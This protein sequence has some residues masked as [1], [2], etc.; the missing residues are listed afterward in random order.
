[1]PPPRPT[2]STRNLPRDQDSAAGSTLAARGAP[3]LSPLTPMVVVVSRSA[4]TPRLRSPSPPPGADA[5]DPLS[6]PPAVLARRPSILPA[7]PPP[8]PHSTP[9]DLHSSANGDAVIPAVRAPAAL[10]GSMPL[11]ADPVPDAAAVSR[12]TE[13]VVLAS[14]RHLPTP[15]SGE[16]HNAV[17]PAP[18]TSPCDT[19]VP[20]GAAADRVTGKDCRDSQ[21]NGNRTTNLGSASLIPS[22]DHHDHSDHSDQ[23]D[24]DDDD[25]DALHRPPTCPVTTI[26]IYEALSGPLGSIALSPSARDIAVPTRTGL[27]ILDLYDPYGDPRL[28]TRLI[29]P[30][31]GNTQPQLQPAVQVAWNPHLARQQW[32]ASTD[33]THVVVWNL[34]HPGSATSTPL[35]TPP[36]SPPP[37]LR[38]TAAASDPIVPLAAYT[39]PAP[40]PTTTSPSSIET[41]LSAHTRAVTSLAWSPAHADMLATSSLDGTVRLWDLRRR[42]APVNTFS[43]WGDPIFAVNWNNVNSW[44]F[45]TAGATGAHVWDVRRGCDPVHTLPHGGARVASVAWHPTRDAQVVTGAADGKVRSWDTV[46]PLSAVVTWDAGFPVARAVYS[47]RGMAVAAVSSR[48]GAEPVRVWSTADAARRPWA[49]DVNGASDVAWREC[50]YHAPRMHHHSAPL[51]PEV[52]LVVWTGA[53]REVSVVPLA[54]VG[55]PDLDHP[56]RALAVVPNSTGWA[57]PPT[58][59]FRGNVAGAT[60]P[61]SAELARA[62]EFRARSATYRA[63]V[64]SARKPVDAEAVAAAAVVVAE[65]VVQPVAAATPTVVPRAAVGLT[66]LKQEVAWVTSRYTN[67]SFES[68]QLDAP[69]AVTAVLHGPWGPA[70][71]LVAVRVTMSFPPNYPHLAAPVIDVVG[72]LLAPTTRAMLLA[73]LKQLAER[74]VARHRVCIEPCL[75]LVLG[76]AVA[77]RP[78]SGIGVALTE[79][80]GRS[81]PDGGLGEEDEDAESAESVSLAG[82]RIDAAHHHHH[83]GGIPRG[84]ETAA[85]AAPVAPAVPTSAATVEDDHYVDHRNY[86]QCIPFPRLAT[87]AWSARGHLAIVLNPWP[88]T[89]AKPSV[90]T[91]TTTPPVEIPRAYDQFLEY[92]AQVLDQAASANKPHLLGDDAASL[93][94]HDEL[95]DEEDM[96]IPT[97]YFAKPVGVAGTGDDLV[98]RVRSKFFPSSSAAAAAATPWSARDRRTS[99]AAVA[100]PVV[101][102]TATPPP[103]AATSLQVP[104]GFGAAGT[105][106]SGATVR[107]G[108]TGT[109]RATPTTVAVT[110]AGGGAA[111]SAVVSLRDLFPTRV[112]HRAVTILDLSPLVPF[113]AYLAR[114]ALVLPRP[115]TLDLAHVCRHNA[116]VS[117]QCGK[118]DHAHMWRAA[119]VVL[120]GRRN[121]VPVDGVR[122]ARAAGTGGAAA[123]AR[124]VVARILAHWE[125]RHDVQALALFASVFEAAMDEDVAAVEGGLG[126]VGSGTMTPGRVPTVSVSN[127]AR[128]LVFVTTTNTVP[129]APAGGGWLAAAADA[130]MAVA[131]RSGLRSVPVSPDPTSMRVTATLATNT[132]YAIPPVPAFPPMSQPPSPTALAPASGLSSARPSFAGSLPGLDAAAAA[133]LAH[134]AAS[135]S[136]ASNPPSPVLMASPALA[137]ADVLHRVHVEFPTSSKSAPPPPP[138]VAPAQ[139]ARAR[140]AQVAYLALVD[141][142]QLHEPRGVL[143][144]ALARRVVRTAGT[145]G[146]A[147]DRAVAQCIGAPRGELE[148]AVGRRCGGRGDPVPSLA[149]PRVPKGAVSPKYCQCQPVMGKESARSFPPAYDAQVDDDDE[150]DSDDDDECEPEGWS[151]SRHY[152]HYASSSYTS[153][154]LV[155]IGASTP[156][157]ADR[158]ASSSTRYLATT[159]PTTTTTSARATGS[160]P[161]QRIGTAASVAVPLSPP[162]SPPTASSLPSSTPRSSAPTA[163]YSL[164]GGGG[165]MRAPGPVPPRG[166]ARVPVSVFGS[167]PPVQGGFV[168]RYAPPPGAGAVQAPTGMPWSVR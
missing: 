68:V 49:V 64:A 83:D 13:V 160:R 71:A 26:P 10:R 16:L 117:A 66:N 123:F 65:P 24:S 56:A 20:D 106:Y 162:Y 9:A 54:S 5:A 161:P 168:P 152:A 128:D 88:R 135:V 15:P 154:S 118:H 72:S 110:T 114:H 59:S 41:V 60:W 112:P 147:A 52:Q 90:A 19:S 17:E 158:T 8:V 149:T 18:S 84:L 27:A 23:S 151:A 34:T 42:P 137:P 138:L 63:L 157:W 99:A 37:T 92:R 125:R 98:K 75:R 164:F 61:P 33:R 131:S 119:E 36:G 51:E 132:N 79:G 57:A 73:Q 155:E 81:S 116:A 3:A 91:T 22:N 121:V 107:S 55:V 139:L 45:A 67:V 111:R 103:S 134:R 122:A 48:G 124:S 31:I 141:A 108:W 167:P 140:A 80:S 89:L 25:D 58:T 28:V 74:N 129:T 30:L 144:R 148:V 53:R 46:A 165:G 62:R 105:S 153:S 97:A 85:T 87:V 35:A 150:H 82:V 2:I 32:V 6:A 4:A 94:G 96:L 47:P 78:V 50:P 104:P 109:D 11:A 146:V 77:A 43:T 136:Q 145:R 113:D 29:P 130:A 7:M 100:T 101:T 86:D 95:V 40:T 159:A 76:Q 166:P 93:L 142:A 1:M 12:D 163:Q 127:S 156:P 14:E 102:V 21:G 133:Q 120:S 69:A 143:A 38:R 115:G 126:V 44:R 70:R 39:S